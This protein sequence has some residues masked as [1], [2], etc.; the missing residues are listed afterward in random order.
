MEFFSLKN[1]QCLMKNKMETKEDIKKRFQGVVG[2]DSA[3]PD[4]LIT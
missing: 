4:T 1:Q 3:I 2:L